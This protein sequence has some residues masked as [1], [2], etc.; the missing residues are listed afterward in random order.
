[1]KKPLPDHYATLGLDR[2]CTVGQ[3]RAAYRVLVKH[4]H[5]DV[6]V[7]SPEA[8]ARTQELNAAYEVLTDAGR[9]R[10]YDRELE[11]A[12]RRESESSSVPEKIEI[13][14][15]QDA[16]LRIDELIRG[17]TLEIRVNDPANPHG[18]EAYRLIV[19]VETAPGT[20]FRIQRAAP[21]ENGFVVVRVKARPDFRFKAR[22]SDLRCD[23][24]IDSRRAASGGTEY[25]TGPTGR[26]SGITIPRGVARGAIIKVPREGLPKANGSRGDLLV[27]ITYRPEVSIMRGRFRG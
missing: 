8:V 18:A 6:N 14:I 13:N 12:D 27:R 4:H 3:V 22:G 23:L 11:T 25:V 15:K 9:R 19:P 7:S 5:P 10:A 16:L 26:R 20:K 24:R 21:F 17:T 1:M 2:R